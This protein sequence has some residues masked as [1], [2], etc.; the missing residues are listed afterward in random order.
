MKKFGALRTIVTAGL[1]VGVLDTSF[2]HCVRGCIDLLPCESEDH[3]S[4]KAG[5]CFRRAL[6]DRRLHCDVL[7]RVAKGIPNI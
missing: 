6:W 7:V 3:I 2:F 1:V 5:R 4:D